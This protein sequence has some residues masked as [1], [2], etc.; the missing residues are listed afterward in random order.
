[1]TVNMLCM[2]DLDGS[3]SFRLSNTGTGIMLAVVPVLMPCSS[4]WSPSDGQCKFYRKQ[5]VKSNFMA[6]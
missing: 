5:I 3:G 4:L 1:M 6:E 2:Y